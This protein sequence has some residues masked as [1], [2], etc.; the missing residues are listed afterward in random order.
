MDERMRAAFDKVRASE[1]LREKTRE[2]VTAALAR[3]TP[4]RRQIRRRVVAIA[5]ACGVLVL[6]AAGALRLALAPAWT[7]S[8]EINPSLELSVS[9]SG[10]VVAAEGFNAEGRALAE[11]VSLYRDYRE[12]VAALLETDTVAGLLAE[13]GLLELSVIDP[14]PDRGAASTAAL[15]PIC[16]G[17]GGSCHQLD[18][19]AVAEAHSC[20]LSYGRYQLYLA[21]VAL[22]P[23]ITP[24]EVASSS[25]RALRQR[26]PRGERPSRGMGRVKP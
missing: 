10:R 15:E 6:L 1:A 21:L 17:A 26:P 3:R 2:K 23:S 18:P 14:N 11:T 7:I 19:D 9:R 22:D 13:D 25:M 20:G 16:A 8:V 4:R 24:E 5:A 12:T